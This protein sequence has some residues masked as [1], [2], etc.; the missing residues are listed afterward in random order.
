M[1]AAEP[2][3]GPERIAELEVKAAKKAR[4]AVMFLDFTYSADKSTSVLHASLQAAAVGAERAVGQADDAAE[5]P[6]GE[7]AWSSRTRSGP[8]PP[9]RSTGCRTKPDTQ[10]LGTTAARRKTPTAAP[11]PRT[12]P[13]AGSRPTT[14][15]SRRS[16]STPAA[17]AIGM[18]LHVHNAVLNRVPNA[19]GEWRTLDSRALQTARAR[20]RERDRRPRRRR[21]HQP[22]ARRRLRAAGRRQGP[23][24][25]GRPPAGQRPVQQ[26]PRGDH[27]RRRGAGRRLRGPPRPPA[28][29]PRPVQHGP[30]R[31]ARQPPRQAPPKARPD[32]GGDA[33]RLDSAGV[34]GRARGAGRHP[35]PR[36]RLLAPG[37]P[38]ITALGAAE[39]DAVLSAA[40]ADVQA[41]LAPPGPAPSSSRRSTRTSP[42][43]SAAW[44]PPPSA[45][46]W[47]TSPTR[48]CPGRT[49]WSAWKRPSWCPCPPR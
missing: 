19:D 46:S 4:S 38:G 1:L 21:D 32:P 26:P 43:G 45:G 37:T 44:T 10:G 18:Q 23:R 36:R 29:S 6:A 48:P 42:G 11:W 16:C 31:D 12:A 40:V 7:A 15:S 9:P 34:G 20:R 13:A 35:R 25:D 41:R 27:P 30:V 47:P 28:V 5:Y 24:A 8:G 33:R 49:A 3:A 22:R 39:V 14:G 17:T 2:G